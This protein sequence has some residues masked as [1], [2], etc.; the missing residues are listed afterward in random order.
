MLSKQILTIFCFALVT[1]SIAARSVREVLGV[2]LR[3]NHPG[4]KKLDLS[5]KGIDD[6]DGLREVATRYPD[7][8]K[9]HLESNRIVEI[10][11]GIFLDFNHLEHLDLGY[12]AI[13]HLY[14]GALSLSIDFGI[15]RKR[16]LDPSR[17]SSLAGLSGLGILS[18]RGNNLKSLPESVGGLRD[19]RGLWL[20][21]NQLSS[22]PESFGGLWSLKKLML[23]SNRL[24]RLPE[25]F[26]DLTVL[27]TLGLSN[28]LLGQAYNHPAMGVSPLAQLLQNMPL[29]EVE[30]YN[31]NLQP[32]VINAVRKTLPNARVVA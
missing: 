3:R 18:L 15:A 11:R 12:N 29:K 32:A 19:L 14:D 10:P 23:N 2:E 16:E 31:N 5:R 13:T 24:S 28:N 1:T 27:G 17:L 8:K 26:G 7:L 21:R 30:L 4:V 9:L 22:L 25:S 6:L 20:E